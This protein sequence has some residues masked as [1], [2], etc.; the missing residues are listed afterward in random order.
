MSES[1]DEG[2]QQNLCGNHDENDDSMSDDG[3]AEEL[4]SSDESD[5]END[6]VPVMPDAA[7]HY[8][9]PSGRAYLKQPLPAVHC[10]NM[11][12]VVHETEGLKP[13]GRINTIDEAFFLFMDDEICKHILTYTNQHAE[14]DEIP[15]FAMNELHAFF[16]ISILMGAH[17]DTGLPASDLWSSVH[18]K[19]VYIAAMS[20]KRYLQ[21]QHCIRFD[22]HDTREERRAQDKYAAIRQVTE[23]INSKFPLFFKPSPHLTVDEMLSLFRGRCSFKVFLKEKPGK[24]GLIYRM[25]SDALHHYILKLEPYA[26]KDHRPPAERS[27]SAIVKRLVEPVEG[28]G[29]N[30]TMDR[31]YT[32]VD[33]AEDLYNQS[34]LT[35]VGTLMSNRR[36]L[37]KEL[38]TAEN[39]ELYSSKFAFTDPRTGQAPVTLVSYTVKERPRKVLCLLSTQHCDKAVS[40]CEKKK[41]QIVEY[42]NLTK[43][44]VDTIDQMVRR[45]SCK[46]GTRRWPLT[47]FYTLLDIICLN[48]YTIFLL[49]KTNWKS[50]KSNRRR[51]FLRE[52][53][54]MLIRGNVEARA[55]NINGLKRNVVHAMEQ[56]LKRPILRPAPPVAAPLVAAQAGAAPKGRCKICVEDI[57]RVGG[58]Y[59]N[60]RKATKRCSSCFGGLCGQH[61]NIMVKCQECF[62]PQDEDSN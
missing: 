38:T 49:N 10:R 55:Q 44:G 25:L 2:E 20:R 21:M 22:D 27:P 12:N 24:Y 34:K 58:K 57:A 40:D 31:F 26:G 45:Y 11:Q 59:R 37:P 4:H 13:A 1:E 35:V 62:V 61:S 23:M 19:N 39:R 50:Q 9:A 46:R 43:G 32:A 30:V 36:H 3:E 16:G 17:E 33:L 18:G 14:N 29:R 7:T 52:L 5:D 56:V 54:E 15:P 51:I 41:P 48:A 8:T 42:Y 53:G 60:A 28:S 47:A 6:R